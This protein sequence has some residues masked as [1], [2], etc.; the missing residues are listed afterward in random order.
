MPTQIRNLQA[1]DASQVF[2][3]IE[4]AR[5]V[6]KVPVGPA[7][8][9]AQ[10][11][12]ECL[13]F[14]LVAHDSAETRAFILW[15]DTGAAWEISFLATHPRYQGQGI[16]KTLIEQLKVAKPADRPLWLEVHEQN[17]IARELY[18]KA[19]FVQTGQRLGYYS[20]GGT[21]VLYNYGDS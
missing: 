1:S 19:G 17:Q 20:D 9:E 5:A 12:T 11:V 6:S 8:T 21:A 18:A 16:M 4:S 7:W 14:G 3:I 2:A 15:R 10:V 13:E